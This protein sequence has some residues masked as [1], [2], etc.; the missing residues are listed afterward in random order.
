GQIYARGGAAGGN[1]G[2]VEISSAGN[3]AEQGLV[4][5]S[6]PHGQ[7]GSLLLDPRTITIVHGGNG[8]GANDDDLGTPPTI[9]FNDANSTANFTSTDGALNNPSG[10]I[11]L[12]ATQ[13]I[14]AGA[15][16]SVTLGNQSLTI[17]TSNGSGNAATNAG[18]INL[19]NATFTITGNG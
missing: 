7:V 13:S 6:A 3:L 8:T 12:Q 15:N 9:Q 11:T 16:V 1:G 17:E 14:T 4:N 19:G 18:N 10:N 5:L 2:N